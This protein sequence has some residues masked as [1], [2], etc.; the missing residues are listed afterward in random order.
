[1]GNMKAIIPIVL[2][3]VIAVTGSFF[4]YQWMQKQTAPIETVRMESHAVP[5]LVASADMTWGTKLRHGMVTTVPFLKESL[6][7][8]YH[9]KFADIQD[10]VVIAPIKAGEPVTEHRLAATDI[11]TGGVSAVLKQ[12]S[13]AIAVKGDKIIGISGFIKPGNRVDVLVTV[14]DPSNDIEKTKIVLQNVLVL[15][16]GTQIEEDEQGKPLPVDVYTLEVKPEE[17]EKL[18]L[19]AA[20]GKIQLALRG[21]IDSDEVVTQGATIA[22]TLAEVNALTESN[23]PQITTAQERRSFPQK[24]PSHTVEIFR[25]IEVTSQKFD[26]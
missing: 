14:K 2:S 22:S 11:K 5:V 24:R 4:I 16:T 9:S 3:L 23:K 19:I 18:A 13:R 8:G 1:M 21:L 20:E 7:P 25:G 12:G 15:A 17:S 26:M 6:P 10:R